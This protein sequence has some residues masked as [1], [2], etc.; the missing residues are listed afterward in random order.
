MM[1]ALRAA[2]GA[3]QPAEAPGAPAKA[4]TAEDPGNPPGARTRAPAGQPGGQASPSPTDSALTHWPVQ[5]ALLPARGPVW[6]GADV[7]LAADCVGFALPDFQ[8]RLL[9]GRNLAVACPKLDETGQYVEKLATVLTDNPPR[10]ITIARMEVPCCGGL[11]RIV[12]EAMTRAGVSLPVQVVTV[13]AEG[14]IV[15]ARAI[16]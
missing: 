12:S 6:Q 2:T 10:S 9:A 4:P 14:Q 8:Q 3:S 1:R 15:S 7:L 16:N 5:L 11:E 13:S